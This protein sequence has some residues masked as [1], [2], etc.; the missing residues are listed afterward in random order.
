MFGIGTRGKSSV[1]AIPDRVAVVGLDLT[2]TRARA[3][4]LA[5][6]RTRTLLLEDPSEDLPLFVAIGGRSPQVGRPGLTQCRKVPHLVC[7]NFLAHLG[8]SQEWRAGRT[9]VTPDDA[10]SITLDALRRP[11]VAESDAVVL[12]VPAYLSPAQA[13]TVAERAAT[14]KLPIR[15]TTTTPLAVA[16]HRASWVLGAA[17]APESNGTEDHILTMRPTGHGPASVVVVDADEFALTASVVGVDTTEAKLVASVAWERA[18]LKAWKDQL[19][20]AVSDRCVRL[21]RRDPRDSADA[22]QALF[23]Q[24]D[25]ALERSRF[26]HPV[27]LSIRGSHWYQDIAHQPEDF[28]AYCTGLAK[29]TAEGVR[30]LIRTANLPVPPRGVWLT[31]AAA[32]LP[33]LAQAVYRATPEQTDVLALPANAVADAAASLAPRWL[34]GRLPRLHLDAAI[35]LESP[36]GKPLREPRPASNG[37]LSTRS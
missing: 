19:V 5:F 29:R 1:P 15:G 27:T 30:E 37:R 23:E 34:T 13:R 8:H 9:R 10:L 4:A 12:T 21:C 2:A 28:D 14:A 36:V 7:T 35:P 32:R 6:G 17:D 31:H 11:V 18:S 16:A 24:L 33:G 26:G 25:T 3:V 22:E 20:D